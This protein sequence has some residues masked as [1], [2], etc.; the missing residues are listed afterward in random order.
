MTENT[1]GAGA[2]IIDGAAIVG[3]GKDAATKRSVGKAFRSGAT[4]TE[5]TRRWLRAN[6]FSS[7]LM[8]TLTV[9]TLLL[10]GLTL[11]P[12]FRWAFLDA[13]FEGPNRSV[14]GAGACW[15][16]VADRLEQFVYGRYTLSERW[17][18]DL[19]LLVLAGFAAAALWPRNS[20]R[21]LAVMLLVTLCPAVAAVLLV[22][23]VFGLP[24]VPTDQWG[25]LS[26]NIILTFATVVLALPLGVVLALGRRSQLPVIR[27]SCTAFIE[28]LRG[29]PLLTVLFMAMVMLPMFLPEGVTFDRLVRAII[30]LSLFV[31][32][33]FAEIIRAGLQGIPK[34]QYEAAAAIGLGF[35]G[36]HRLIVLPQAFRLVVPG[37]VNTVIDLF[38]DTTLVSIIGLFDLLG[39]VGQSIKDP[40]WLGL[41]REGYV[42]A[43]LIFFVCC[44]AMS[45]LSLRI[46]RR[47]RSASH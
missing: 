41:G 47:I 9:L 3:T 23:G 42:F 44:Y 15:A 31:A 25:G 33:Y 37:I 6:L 43:A 34:G 16:F 20:H 14:C 32:A 7:P 38:K 46:E 11:P 30:G 10:L 40:N 13:V 36:A 28:M 22:G 45:L 21:T 35:W 18:V 17:R 2:A 27:W 8:G 5:R 39:I 26:L 24:F 4:A 12:L 29:V 1:A 19:A